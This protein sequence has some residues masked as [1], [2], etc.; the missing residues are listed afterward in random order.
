[1]CTSSWAAAS[2]RRDRAST[3][4]LTI[5]VDWII[6]VCGC[7]AP[8]V[9][10]TQVG[11]YSFTPFIS[12]AVS[13]CSA[14]RKKEGKTMGSVGKRLLTHSTENHS[15]SGL[16][17]SLFHSLPVPPIVLYMVLGCAGAV[18][19]VSYDLAAQVPQALKLDGD[20]EYTHDPSIAK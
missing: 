17:R 10:R 8:R 6:A 14:K 1:M 5:F 4:V 19:A 12:H 7:Q 3:I 9:G 20:V 13:G 15:P 11:V 18:F 16:L 2:V